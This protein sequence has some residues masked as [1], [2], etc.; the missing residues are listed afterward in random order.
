VKIYFCNAEPI[1]LNAI[2][3]MGVSVKTGDNPIGY[4]GTGLKFAIATL[5]R[6]GHKITLVRN[7]EEIPFSVA[8]ENIRGED[9]AR[10]VMGNE[11]LGFTTQLGR[12]WEPWQAY[13]ELRCNCIDEAG[14]IADELPAGEWGTIFEIEG[15]AIAECHR[16]RREIFLESSPISA[17]EDCAIHLGSTEFAFYR[18]VRAHQHGRRAL[19]TYNIIDSVSLTE[20]RTIKS[21]WEVGYYVERAIAACD[22]EGIIEEALMAPEGSFEAGLD[23]SSAGKPTLAFMDVAFRLR[24]NHHCNKGAI[25]LWEK[26]SD[27]RMSFDEAVL[28]AFDEQ[29]LTQAMTL[30]KR[31]G[32]DIDRRDFTVVESLGASIFGTVRKNRILI[33]K[34]TLDLGVRFIASTLYEEWLHKTQSLNDETREL[35]NLLFEKLMAMTERVSALEAAAGKAFS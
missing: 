3:I 18:G 24:A 26:H 10:V 11:R 6:T 14:K 25:K 32:A 16:Q 17:T 21:A 22:D 28:D 12:N 35:Q 9:F 1:D 19:F 20:D 27:I 5:L 29:Q 15:D 34:A 4:F 31:L 23:Y 2:A 33:A 7:G 13:R 8:S 30:I